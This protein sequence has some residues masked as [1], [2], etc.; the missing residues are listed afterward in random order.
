MPAGN[1]YAV[2]ANPPHRPLTILWLKRAIAH[3]GVEADYIARHNPEAAQRM[4]DVIARAVQLLAEHPPWAARGA[5]RA[6][7]SWSSAAR[8]TLLPV[9]R[10]AKPF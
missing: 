3:L 10:A 2:A 9:V 6:P 5:S 7:A 8:L 4:L 1:A